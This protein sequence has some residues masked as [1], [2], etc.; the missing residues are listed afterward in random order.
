MIGAASALGFVSGALI[1]VGAWLT[2]ATRRAR[3][4]IVI[5]WVAALITSYGL[6]YPGLAQAAGHWILS[7]DPEA[8]NAGEI[9]T[10][11]LGLMAVIWLPFALLALALRHR[12]HLPSWGLMVGFGGAFGVAVLPGMVGLD[13]RTGGK[14]AAAALGLFALLSLILGGC[15]G[16]SHSTRGPFDV[17]T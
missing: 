6:V 8:I 15:A 10:I 17:P 1:A 3:T 9:R 14:D 11:N 7:L 13:L 12:L 16:V 5:A 2:A 4:A